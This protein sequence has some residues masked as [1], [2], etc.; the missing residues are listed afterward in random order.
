LSVEV[1]KAAAIIII[2]A[3]VAINVYRLLYKC[4]NNPLTLT[5]I[6][7]ITFNAE[8]VDRLTVN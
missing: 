7:I 1:A 5:A 2:T 3:V 8:F 6:F 4:H